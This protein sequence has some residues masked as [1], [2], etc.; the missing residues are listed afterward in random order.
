MASKAIIDS[1]P[2]FE[3]IFG[4]LGTIGSQIQA[5]DEMKKRQEWIDQQGKMLTGIM[6]P[7]YQPYTDALAA[8]LMNPGYDQQLAGLGSSQ[9]GVGLANQYA[10]RASAGQA[11]DTKA[12]EQALQKEAQDVGQ[13]MDVAGTLRGDN[14][15][16][17]LRSAASNILSQNMGALDAALGARGLLGSSVGTTA[18]RGVYGDVF[19][20]LA[21]EISQNELARLQAAGQLGTGWNQL[22][23]T[24]QTARLGQLA[25]LAGLQNQF[26]LGQ[27][28]INA[29]LAG[30]MGGL[31]NQLMGMQADIFQNLNAQ[32]LSQLGN[33]LAGYQYLLG[34]TMNRYGQGSDIINK[35][36]PYPP[37]QQPS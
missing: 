13:V 18:A 5:P 15:Y 3:L 33:Y 19:S 10:A 16:A 9:G 26:T 2:L 21:N 7:T 4:G 11:A 20:N 6:N 27:G 23:N 34:D 22:F 32:R 36:N 24:E 30:T 1:I 12:L 14:S 17:N 35:T 25:N 28:Q 8:M 29:G 31:G 37:F